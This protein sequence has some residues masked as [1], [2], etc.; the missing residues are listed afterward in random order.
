MATKKTAADS[1]S[2]VR[3]PQPKMRCFSAI[4]LAFIAFL[5][6][7]VLAAGDEDNF[8][9]EVMLLR[10]GEC[11]LQPCRDSASFLVLISSPNR[12]PALASSTALQPTPSSPESTPIPRTTA[13]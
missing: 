11:P 1:I 8:E 9:D 13:A 3:R 2:F 12:S 10:G 7:L 6:A 4:I 5:A